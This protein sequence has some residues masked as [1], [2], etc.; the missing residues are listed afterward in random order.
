MHRFVAHANV[1]H[2]LNLLNGDLTPTDRRGIT[3]LLVVEEDKLVADLQHLEFAETRAASGRER[4][5]KLKSLRDGF[6]VGTPERAQ[7]DSLLIIFENTQTMLEDFCHRIRDTIS[8]G[9]V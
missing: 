3:R 5:G 1:D 9:G 4:V 6:A 7:A 2:Y 8:R